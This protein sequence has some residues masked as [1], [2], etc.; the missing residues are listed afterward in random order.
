M[1]Q[2]LMSVGGVGTVSVTLQ[3]NTFPRRLGAGKRGYSRCQCYVLL[4]LTNANS[5]GSE[6]GLHSSR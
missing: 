4:T 1:T 2:M 5:V 3:Q 6:S